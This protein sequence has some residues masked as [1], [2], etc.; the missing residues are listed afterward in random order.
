MD[1]GSFQFDNMLLDLYT[2][3]QHWACACVKAAKGVVNFYARDPVLRAGE[4]QSDGM[5]FKMKNKP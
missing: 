5:G 1:M 3:C 2:L 4:S